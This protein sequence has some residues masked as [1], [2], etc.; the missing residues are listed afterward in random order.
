MIEQESFCKVRTYVYYDAIIYDQ[1]CDRRVVK[2]AL[3]HCAGGDIVFVRS[4]FWS[5][6]ACVAL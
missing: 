3:S 4:D 1:F 2:K 6:S 5:E